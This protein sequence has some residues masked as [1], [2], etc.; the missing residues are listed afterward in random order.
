MVKGRKHQRDWLQQLLLRHESGSHPATLHYR[1]NNFDSN[2]ILYGKALVVA[3][4]VDQSDL[5]FRLL[6]RKYG[7]NLCVT[8]MIHARMFVCNERGYKERFWNVM[9]GTPAEDRPLIVQFAGG[10]PEM[11]AQAAK[12]VENQCDAVDI[13]CGCPQ[14]IA[15]RGNY[16]AFL[17][18][19]EELLV[20]CVEETVKACTIPVCVKVRLLPSGLED[21]LRLY[22]RLVDAG[23]AML[24]IHGRNRFNKG[25]LTGRANWEAIRSVVDALGDRVPILANGSVAD[26]NDCRAC[27][28][29]TGADGK[30]LNLL[31]K[32]R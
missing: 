29:A 27:L 24:T 2:D 31:F 25:P 21:S 4:M 32:N 15:K 23:A 12:L 17:L 3:P 30:Y 7:S 16:G 6:A 9:K 20:R 18:E 28:R 14:M 5:P 22:T 13:N 26:L 11:L 8:P 10:D 19:N 1:V